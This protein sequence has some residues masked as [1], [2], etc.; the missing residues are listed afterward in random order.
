MRWRDVALAE[1]RY[2]ARMEKTHAMRVLD[3]RGVAYETK[4]Y[5]ASGAFHAAD[6]AAALI[7][8]DAASVY[9]TLVV[10]RDDGTR[11]K[12]MLVMV[13]AASQIDLKLLAKSV[14]AKKLRMATQREAEQLTGMR[15]GGI[16]ALGLKQPSRF[17]VLIDEPASV[18]ET[19]HV[20]AG[21]RGIDLALRAAD[22][23]QTAGAKLVRA[24]EAPHE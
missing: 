21:A 12:P 2:A 10:L 3:A 4:T 7:G 11:G 15:V 5:D 1:L 8:A 19:I 22:L 14:G 13:A 16:S 9:K 18:I 23:I 20:S 6:E 17:D 24:C